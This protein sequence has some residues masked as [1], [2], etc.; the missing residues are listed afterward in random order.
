MDRCNG[1]RYAALRCGIDLRYRR[2]HSVNCPRFVRQLPVELSEDS[3]A[4]FALDCL[5]EQRVCNR[6]KADL[7]VND[8][9][10]LLVRGRGLRAR[11]G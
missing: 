10:S 9:L 3:V 2:R 6:G 4:M 7:S 11:V 8:G 1:E 5:S